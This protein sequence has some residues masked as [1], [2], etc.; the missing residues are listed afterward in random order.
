MENIVGKVV[1]TDKDEAGNIIYV[2]TNDDISGIRFTGDQWCEIIIR[3]SLS[4][5]SLKGLIHHFARVA[6]KEYRKINPEYHTEDSLLNEW[7]Q[8]FGMT[9]TIRSP[10]GE[11]FIYC[12]SLGDHIT[13]SDSGMIWDQ[14]TSSKFY[15]NILRWAVEDAKVKTD[16]FESERRRRK[17]K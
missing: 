17:N 8:R 3:G 13:V 12:I 10:G 5:H 9:K 6:L 1:G 11:I 7:K 14:D 2:L 15:D 16:E 4:S